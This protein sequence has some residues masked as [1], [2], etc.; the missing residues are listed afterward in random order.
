MLG[1]EFQSSATAIL[2]PAEL[3]L[4]TLSC[5]QLGSVVGF[6]LD[7]LDVKQL[8]S[9]ACNSLSI[10]ILQFRSFNHSTLRKKYFLFYVH[11]CFACCVRVSYPLEQQTDV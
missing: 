7:I 9:W 6:L 3:P 10:S 4:S 1:T 11:W 8:L 2:L 5:C